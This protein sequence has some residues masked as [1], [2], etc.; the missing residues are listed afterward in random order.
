VI[1]HLVTT[2]FRH[3]EEDFQQQKTDRKWYIKDHKQKSHILVSTADITGH[4]IKHTH[5]YA[6]TKTQSRS[7]D[8]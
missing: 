5:T 1:Q 3:I 6:H 8:R 2:K 4:I 7:V